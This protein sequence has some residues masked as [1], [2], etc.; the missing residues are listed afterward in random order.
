MNLTESERKL[1]QSL[2]MADVARQV[3]GVKIL[4]RISRTPDLTA[5]TV[6]VR[7]MEDILRK[8]GVQVIP[9]AERQLLGLNPT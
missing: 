2:I 4:R 3:Q 8:L 1:L 5:V 7:M 6:E 9:D